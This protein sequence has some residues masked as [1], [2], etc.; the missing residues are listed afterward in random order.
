M[1]VL[2]SFFVTMA[3]MAVVCGPLSAETL[4]SK[5]GRFSVSLPATPT[6]NKSRV[7]LGDQSMEVYSYS[8]AVKGGSLAI[9]YSDLPTGVPPADRV[10]AVLDGAANGIVTNTKGTL[11]KSDKTE[12][13]GCPGRDV[14]WTVK[15]SNAELCGRAR[16]IL[17]GE[18]MYQ[19]LA[20]GAEAFV[21]SQPTLDFFDSFRFDRAPKVSPTAKPKTR[22][23]AAKKARSK[24]TTAP[25]DTPADWR[26][27]G[28]KN[29]DGGYTVQVPAKPE[30][31]QAPGIL[32][33]KNA[34]TFTCSAEGLTFTIMGQPVPESATKTG[35]KAVLKSSRDSL[36]QAHY[37][38]ASGIKSVQVADF[39]GCEF[40]VT[41]DS[42]TSNV[43]LARAVLV[44]RRLYT[45]S[46]TGTEAAVARP[47][48]E[49]FLS[50]FKPTR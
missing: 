7:Q 35:S 45:L 39:P 6:M 15:A 12:H 29:N 37:G 22:K 17:V 9:V 4:A 33:V 34:T 28:V 8:A 38:T 23:P 25:T 19:V 49:K 26:N 10:D 14:L 27:F 20:V 2:Q 13:A 1:R 3:V 16:L 48:A 5:E 32:G 31:G 46:V 21:A 44:G 11:I 41:S 47:A 50:S 24:P 36:A 18:R 43:T 42:A 40:R 30:R